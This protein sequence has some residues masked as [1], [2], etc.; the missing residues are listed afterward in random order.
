MLGGRFSAPLTISDFKNCP[1][2]LQDIEREIRYHKSTCVLKY[3][4][5]YDFIKDIFVD[6]LNRQAK[7]DA[8]KHFPCILVNLRHESVMYTLVMRNCNTLKWFFTDTKLKHARRCEICLEKNRKFKSCF[9]CGNRCCDTCLKKIPSLT[10]PFCKY[11]S[12][13]HHAKMLDLYDG[14]L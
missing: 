12:I 8:I 3:H 4:G 6:S 13:E 10:C 5:A 2:E 1:Y 14:S 11:D 7:A 9:R